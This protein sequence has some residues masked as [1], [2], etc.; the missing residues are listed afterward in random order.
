MTEPVILDAPEQ[1]Y[2]PHNNV[3]YPVGAGLSQMRARE[4]TVSYHQH[5]YGWDVVSAGPK[6]S[7]L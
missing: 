7:S 6:T 2:V 3:R 1:R 5:N 4:K